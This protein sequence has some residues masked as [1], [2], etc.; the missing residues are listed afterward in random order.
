MDVIVQARLVTIPTKMSPAERF[1]DLHREIQETR[2]VIAK[3][4]EG[5]DVSQSEIR[6][7]AFRA[8]C[9]G[10]LAGMLAPFVGLELDPALTQL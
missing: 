2:D 1:G 9:W 10:E 7:A 6:R 3:H 8:Q 4:R 5:H